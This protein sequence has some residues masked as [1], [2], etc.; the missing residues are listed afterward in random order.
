MTMMVMIRHICDHY[1]IIKHSFTPAVELE[2]QQNIYE[3]D[4]IICFV[5]GCT[6]YIRGSERFLVCKGNTGF[7]NEEKN[8][9]A[10]FDVF[11]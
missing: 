8:R 5:R 6:N 9:S 3:V 11:Q 1:I 10:V 7:R 4:L 2:V